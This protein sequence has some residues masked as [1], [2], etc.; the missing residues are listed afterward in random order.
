MKRMLT[1][2]LVLCLL[3]CLAACGSSETK[4]TTPA[5]TAAQE[6]PADTTAAETEAQETEAAATE[7]DTGIVFTYKDCDI[8]MNAPAESIIA[9]L[10]EPMSYT[11]ETSCA[12]EGLDKTYYYGSFYMVTY[13][14]G[15]NDFVYTLWFADDSVTTAEGVYI[16][17]TKAD[18]ETAYGE[19]CFG[20]GNSY[21]LEQ[22]DAKLTIILTDGVVSGI[23]Y[24][25]IVE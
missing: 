2:T 10:G 17:A 22:D 14:V 23:R 13:P 15:D 12:F 5:T 3:L 11:E 9:A 19:G 24:D 4:D 21:T 18:V 6:V 25:A 1:L 7:A 16:G 8:A 20:D